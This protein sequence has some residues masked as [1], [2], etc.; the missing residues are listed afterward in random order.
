MVHLHRMLRPIGAV[1]LASSASIALCA[2][3]PVASA[4]AQQSDNDLRAENQALKTRVRDLE[5]EL[6]AARARAD[7]LDKRLAEMEAKLKAAAAAAPPGS[8]G[9]VG[10]GQVPPPQPPST[11]VDENVMNASPPALLKA[12]QADYA[13]VL[14]AAGPYSTPKERTVYFRALEKW[15]AGANRRFRVPIDWLV[16]TEA[17]GSIGDRSAVLR[18]VAIDPGNGND[19]G[20]PFD[21]TV[22]I[23]M[24]HRAESAGLA[25]KGR[26]IVL[27]GTLNPSVVLNEKRAAVGA[28]DKPKFIGPFAELGFGVEASSVTSGERQ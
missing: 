23:A 1:V 8:A 14:G 10:T 11:T 2:A 17:V 12:M 20:D 9:A 3:A 28:F 16:R 26:Q 6:A 24:F 19:L 18:V 13:Q 4:Q 22:P 25:A 5:L 7:D 15:V 27:R 21:V